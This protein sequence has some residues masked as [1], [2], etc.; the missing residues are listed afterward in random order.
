MNREDYAFGKFAWLGWRDAFLGLVVMP[1]AV[2]TILYGIV[3]GG[4]RTVR[5]VLRGF[6]Q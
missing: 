4:R 5:W 6:R 3:A 1:I 2:Y